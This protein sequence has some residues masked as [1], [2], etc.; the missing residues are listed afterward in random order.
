VS[1]A[2]RRLHRVEKRCLREATSRLPLFFCLVAGSGFSSSCNSVGAVV[3]SVAAD[4]SKPNVGVQS[5]GIC[6]ISAPSV[7]RPSHPRRAPRHLWNLCFLCVIQM[8][9]VRG[10]TSRPRSGNESALGRVLPPAL[11][12]PPLPEGGHQEEGFRP[13]E[14]CEEVRGKEGRGSPLGDAPLREGGAP[15]GRGRTRPLETALRQRGFSRSRMHS[16]ARSASNC[17]TVPSFFRGSPLCF[18]PEWS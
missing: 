4:D 11:R 12:A 8:P 1:L 15:K 16:A 10:R 7:R 17:G 9:W 3:G 14:G 18:A 5:W 2:A 6:G 13:P